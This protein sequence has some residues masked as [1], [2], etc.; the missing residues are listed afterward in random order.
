MLHNHKIALYQERFHLTTV[1][2]GQEFAAVH[3][4]DRQNSEHQP[5]AIR[6]AIADLQGDL[7][8]VNQIIRV[9]EWLTANASAEEG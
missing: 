4:P 2:P 6:D 8:Q 7:A 1:D 9:L 5:A 3:G